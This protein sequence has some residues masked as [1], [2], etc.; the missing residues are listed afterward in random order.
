MKK[1][2]FIITLLLLCTFCAMGQRKKDVVYSKDVTT[3]KTSK[4]YSNCI[5]KGHTF[6]LDLGI[7][8]SA[9]GLWLNGAEH[10]RHSNW[11][12]AVGP[13][14]TYNFI[15]YFG[16]DFIKV[17]CIIGLNAHSYRYSF[18]TGGGYYCAAQFLIGIRGNTPT[19]F[20]CMSGYMAFRLGY[21]IGNAN[22]KYADYDGYLDV[23]YAGRR[24]QLLS[25]FCFETELGLNLTK[26]VFVGLVF[27]MQGY[28]APEYV[29][30]TR[31]GDTFALRVGFNF[32]KK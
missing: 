18:D 31:Y 27:N 32:G 23:Y 3:I 26:M 17:N 8:G 13:R 30:G 19:F 4:N 6:G 24:N 7:G 21:G 11:S 14:Y 2:L 12:L 9:F 28:K 10:G 1:N 22:Y 20:K 5:T 25:G 15:P 29:G 16:V